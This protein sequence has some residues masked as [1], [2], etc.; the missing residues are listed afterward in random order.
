MCIVIVILFKWS[1]RSLN[2][3]L[4]SK[5]YDLLTDT[6]FR[7]LAVLA[8]CTSSYKKLID[9]KRNALFVTGTSVCDNGMAVAWYRFQNDACTQ[10]AT[11]CPSTHHCNTHATGWLNGAHPSEAEGIVT[12]T[13]CFNWSSG[14]CTWSKSIRVVNCGSFYLY[15]LGPSPICN[16]RYCGQWSA[17]LWKMWVVLRPKKGLACK[18]EGLKIHAQTSVVI[19][20]PWRLASV[21]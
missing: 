6:S 4:S 12:R 15:E 11:T 14:C 16:G 8:V 10:M 18:Y 2:E 17:K 13:V 1:Q 19:H 7:F 5:I 3:A 9:P 21:P 20:F